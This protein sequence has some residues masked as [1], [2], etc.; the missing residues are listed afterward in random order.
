MLVCNTQT[1]EKARFGGAFSEQR[2]LRPQK[3]FHV[4]L[5]TLCVLRGEDF[6]LIADYREDTANFDLPRTNQERSS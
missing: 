6:G 3:A 1:N 4:V 5:G 2:A